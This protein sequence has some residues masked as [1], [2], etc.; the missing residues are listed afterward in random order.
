VTEVDF[1][2][3][4]FIDVY[5]PAFTPRLDFIKTAL[6]LSENIALLALCLIQ[7]GVIS[8]EGKINTRCLG[9]SLI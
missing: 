7:T 6:Q 9:V 5:V 1:L 3:L 8:K 2:S 4:V